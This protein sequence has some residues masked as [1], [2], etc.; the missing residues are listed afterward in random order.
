[1][2]RGVARPATAATKQQPSL[3][4]HVRSTFGSIINWLRAGYPDDAPHIGYSPLL[5]L[6]GSSR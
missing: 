6:N 2:R 4:A 1:M 5:A 3:L